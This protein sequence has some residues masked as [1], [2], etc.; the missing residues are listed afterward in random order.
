MKNLLSKKT[1]KKGFTLIEL[2]I[3]LAIMAIIAAIAIP[4]FAAVRNNS[5]KKADIQSCE[6]IKRTILTLVAD[7]TVTVSEDTSATV[8]VNDAAKTVTVTLAAEDKFNEAGKVEIEKALKEIKAPQ[9]DSSTGYKISIK[10]AGDVDVQVLP[11]SLNIKS[12]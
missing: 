12:K 7:E 5:R 1:K 11:E 4:S 10:K 8:T 2:I 9:T 6:T 3:V